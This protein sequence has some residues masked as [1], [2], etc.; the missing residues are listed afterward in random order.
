MTM[1]IDTICPFC[2]QLH[3][4]RV[5]REGYLKYLGGELIQRALPELTTTEKE[6]LI[7]GLCPECQEKFFDAD[8][9]EDDE[10]EEE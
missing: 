8:F 5:N 9:Y 10:E 7:S 1:T 6:Q 4:V 3:D 2:G